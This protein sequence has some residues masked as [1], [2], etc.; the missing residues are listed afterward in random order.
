MDNAWSTIETAV[1]EARSLDTV[2]TMQS[3]TLARLLLKRLRSIDDRDLLVELKRELQQ[4][5]AT[6]KKWK[7]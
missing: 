2:I 3:N 6:V 5:D 7:R 4:F 1:R